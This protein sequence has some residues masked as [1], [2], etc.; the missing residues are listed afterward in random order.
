MNIETLRA[1]IDAKIKEAKARGDGEIPH[2][3]Y[4]Y[5]AGLYDAFEIITK[6]NIGPPKSEKRLICTHCQG[7]GRV[8]QAGKNDECPVCLGEGIV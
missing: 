5:C 3:T 1:I 8:F 4:W 7:S 2:S 6:Q